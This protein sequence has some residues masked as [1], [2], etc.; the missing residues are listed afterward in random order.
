MEHLLDTLLSTFAF[1]NTFSY[2]PIRQMPTK[3]CGHIFGIKLIST[4]QDSSA[5][6]N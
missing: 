5:G 6:I 4:N 1:S 3:A 2:N